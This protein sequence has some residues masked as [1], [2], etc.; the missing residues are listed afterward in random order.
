MWSKRLNYLSLLVLL[1][2]GLIFYHH[3]VLMLL[4]VIMLASPVVSYVVTKKS[5]DKFS[6][7]TYSNRASVGKHVP[8]DVYFDIENKSIIPVENLKIDIKIHN[9]FYE[10]KEEYSIIVPSVPM[11]SRSAKISLSG[12]YCGRMLVEAVNMKIQD[13]FGLFEF[14]KEISCVTEIFIMPSKQDSFEKV[15]LSVLGVSEDEELQF[16]KGDDVSQISQIRAYVPGDRL[17]NIH[18]KLSAKSEEL[19]VKEFSMPYSEDVILLLEFYVDAKEPEVFDELIETMYAFSMDLIRQG[20]KFAVM[21][22]GNGSYE[23]ESMEVFNEDD[24]KTVI[25]ELYYTEPQK[26]NGITYE[27]FSTL[28][29]ELKGTVLYLSDLSVA[30]KTGTI[31][32]IGSEKVVLTCLQ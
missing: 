29:S 28:N 25:N 7:K 27:L 3:Y 14:R 30:D 5:I 19:Q 12:I 10:N 4:L 18:W 32:D 16:V 24:L 2:F 22:H 21:Y 6:I 26:E 31:F 13:V 15:N 9:Y 20:R 8:V 17:Q 1:G 23:L 11:K